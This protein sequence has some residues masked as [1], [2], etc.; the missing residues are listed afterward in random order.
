[1]TDDACAAFV[2]KC[3]FVWTCVIISKTQHFYFKKLTELKYFFV[4]FFVCIFFSFFTVFLWWF[5]SEISLVLWK[6]WYKEC[7]C[8]CVFYVTGQSQWAKGDS[9]WN[10]LLLFIFP[11]LRYHHFPHILAMTGDVWCDRSVAGVNFTHTIQLHT[12]IQ[13]ILNM[14]YSLALCQSQG[15]FET[16]VSISWI[17]FIF[18]F[19]HLCVFSISRT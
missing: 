18:A 5:N 7:I 11:V 2:V 13:L 15:S 6:S 17:I 14:F 3:V 4:C 9:V 8:V 1:M 10:L 12:L 16:L 19:H